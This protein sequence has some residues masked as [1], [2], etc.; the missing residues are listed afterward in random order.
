MVKEHFNNA[1][2]IQKVWIDKNWRR[3]EQ[4]AIW[5][6]EK[7]LGWTV[8]KFNLVCLPPYYI[9]WETYLFIMKLK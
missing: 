2:K 3:L 8:F 5:V 9:C 4:I 6:F 7:L 1:T